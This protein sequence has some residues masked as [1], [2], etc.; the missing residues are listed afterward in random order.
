MSIK[1][2]EQI[3]KNTRHLLR[4]RRLALGL[5]MNRTGEKAGLSQQ[6]ISYVERGLRDPTL[7]TLL[8]ICEALDINMSEIL[9]SAEDKDTH[10]KPIP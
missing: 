1:N 6:T 10:T 8:R 5:S 7:G 3:I 4:A 2:R 9:I